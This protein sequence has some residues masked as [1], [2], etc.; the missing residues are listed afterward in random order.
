MRFIALALLA[1]ALGG[2]MSAA[3]EREPAMQAQTQLPGHSWPAAGEAGQVRDL[4][5]LEALK[6]RSSASLQRRILGAAFEAKDQRAGRD[7]L[8]RLGAMGYQLSD[9]TLEQLAS[10]LREGELN[11][12]RANLKRQVHP[13]SFSQLVATIPAEYPL[14]DSIAIQTSTGRYFS[15]SVVDRKLI[16]S[17]DNGQS[18]Q[19]VGVAFDGRPM[20]LAIDQERNWL[21][22][23]MGRLGDDEGDFI[24]L[25]AIDLQTFEAVMRVQVD[26]TSLNDISVGA[27]GSVYASDSLGGG[28]YR[29]AP[30]ASEVERLD[31]PGTFRSPQGIAVH[32]LGRFIYVADY[33]YGIAILGLQGGEVRQLSNHREMFDGIDGL[34]MLDDFHLAAIQ[35]GTNPQRILKISVGFSGGRSVEVVDVERAHPDWGEPTTGQLIDNTLYYIADP[36]WDR[37]G[38]GGVIEGDAP[39]RPNQIRSIRIR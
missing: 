18:W 14:A 37:V 27:D 17:L 35:N 1:A 6:F 31:I 39:L 22:I 23:S 30:G 10:F 20:S 3:N 33:A 13:L 16:A 19:E 9:G 21:W 5:E 8:R 15:V 36:Q 24:G 11:R 7:A 34:F 26:A 32:P 38:A 29:L 28:V 2:C 4:E 25:T 12:Y